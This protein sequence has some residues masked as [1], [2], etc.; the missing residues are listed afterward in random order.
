MPI[1]GKP[2][3]ERRINEMQVGASGFIKL[4]ALA[5]DLNKV[6]YLCVIEPINKR[7]NDAFKIPIKRTGSGEA[8]YDLD[9]RKIKYKWSLEE[10]PF[11]YLFDEDD[12]EIQRKVVELKY[13]DSNPRQIVHKRRK[14]TKAENLERE[15]NLA[16]RNEEY[17][18]AGKIRDQIRRIKSKV[19]EAK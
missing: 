10:V 2:R 18:L 9:L 3:L 16:I 6:P 8:D 14:Y 15:L 11:S 5:F 4:D 19:R 17:E 1:R 12:D 7:K 13:D